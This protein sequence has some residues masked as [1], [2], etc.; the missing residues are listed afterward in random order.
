MV[1]LKAH[2][3]YALWTRDHLCL[4]ILWMR[5]ADHMPI[6]H[7][8]FCCNNYLIMGFCHADKNT[9]QS[10]TFPLMFT[11]T[12]G[13]RQFKHPETLI[14]IIYHIILHKTS[15]INI[16]RFYCHTFGISRESD[17]ILQQKKNENKLNY[18]QI[19]IICKLHLFTRK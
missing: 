2:D 12:N 4:L 7:C 19:I 17:F 10:Y 1:L 14:L 16:V 15:S 8:I 3:L 18:H 11:F 13:L 5:P 6:R 9:D